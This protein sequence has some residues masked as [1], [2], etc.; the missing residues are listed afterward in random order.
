MQPDFALIFDMDG[1]LIDSERHWPPLEAGL[2]PRLA[3]DWSAADQRELIGMSPHDLF[4]KLVGRVGFA[5]DKPAFMELYI[6]AGRPIYEERCELAPGAEALLRGAVVAGWPTA[7]ASS[8]PRA[9]VDMAT[10]RFG[11]TPLFGAIVSGDDAAR[12]KPAPDIFLLAAQRL[13]VSPA[14]C[15]VL[16]DSNRGARAA[17]AAGMICVGIDNGYNHDQDL[18]MTDQIARG[19]EGL[20]V[21]GL[22]RLV[23]APR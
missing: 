17:K 10:G 12:G 2:M 15:V 14:Q 7:L 20:T 9:W 19:L 21:D 3:A 13:G 5:L 18:R 1:V 11:L 8:S 6:N 22:R 23:G 16:E 4:E